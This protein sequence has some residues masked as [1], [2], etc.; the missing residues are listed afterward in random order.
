MAKATQ[1]PVTPELIESWRT[2]IRD[3]DAL[4]ANDPVNQW[5]WLWQIRR[6]ILAHLLHRHTGTHVPASVD[7]PGSPPRLTPAAPD[8]AIDAYIRTASTID[9]THTGVNPPREASQLRS[10]LSSLQ[11]V[12][13]ARY[14]QVLR[15][16]VGHRLIGIS[17]RGTQALPK[18]RPMQYKIRLTRTFPLP[19]TNAPTILAAQERALVREHALAI[20]QLITEAELFI[21]GQE[22]LSED[23]IFAILQGETPD[24]PD[25]TFNISDTSGD[26][27]PN[28]RGR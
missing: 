20:Q 12:N 7:S 16:V 21:Q 10:R 3:L 28:L 14:A 9:Q 1:Q 8:A 6:D 22:A 24:L 11:N 15:P 19:P 2:R 23:Q 27:D 5:C 17:R 26:S 25:N 18:P 4:I 13:A